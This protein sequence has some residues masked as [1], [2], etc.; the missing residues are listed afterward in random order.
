MREEEKGMEEE[1]R[2]AKKIE[3]TQNQGRKE[4]TNL[5]FYYLHKMLAF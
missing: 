1:G 2:E 4:N 3:R 5:C